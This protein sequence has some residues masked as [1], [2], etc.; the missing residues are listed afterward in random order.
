MAKNSRFGK[1]TTAGMQE[2]VTSNAIPET[3]KS[4]KMS[5]ATDNCWLRIDGN[6]QS[7]KFV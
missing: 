7:N 6:I 5:Q 1:L 2:R 4:Y 3:T